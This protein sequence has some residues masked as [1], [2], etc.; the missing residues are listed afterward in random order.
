M[1]TNTKA[2]NTQ[3]KVA[4]FKNSLDFPYKKCIFLIRREFLFLKEGFLLGFILVIKIDT[5]E[6]LNS[7]KERVSAVQGHRVPNFFG[8]EAHTPNFKQ[9]TR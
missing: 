6:Q 8:G 2:S 7:W 1:T 4:F 9:V 5:D 3:N